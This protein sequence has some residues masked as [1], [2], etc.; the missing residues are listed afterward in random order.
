MAVQVIDLDIDN[1]YADPRG[2][3]LEIEGRTELNIDFVDYVPTGK[4][5]THPIKPGETL[6][7]ITQIY[8][9]AAEETPERW[10]WIIV[11]ANPGKI[12]DPLDISDLEGE[13][14]IIPSTLSPQ[15]SS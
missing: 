1:P 15:F 9:G 2:Y 13:T 7:Q 6:D 4:E 14:I 11:M 8:F 5:P 3:T 12:F 10:Y